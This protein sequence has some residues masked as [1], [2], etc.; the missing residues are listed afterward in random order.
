MGF[1]PASWLTLY[2]IVNLAFFPFQ[3]QS[4]PLKISF[5]IPIT[6]TKVFISCIPVYSW[7]IQWVCQP[8]DN[9]LICSQAICF[10]SPAYGISIKLYFVENWAKAKIGQILLAVSKWFYLEPNRSIKFDWVRVVIDYR[11]VRSVR[12]CLSNVA[13]H[14]WKT[15]TKTKDQTKKSL[16]DQ[17]EY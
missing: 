14:P 3:F 5:H 8:R 1:D 2:I 15:R 4:I 16:M 10:Q 9:V 6:R 13:W 12:V 7:A 11:T 17:L